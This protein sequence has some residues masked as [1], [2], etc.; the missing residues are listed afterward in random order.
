MNRP[1]VILALVLA[2]QLL[3]V[4]A[5]FWPGSNAA[6]DSAT[7]PLLDLQADTIDRLI[8]ADGTTSVMLARTGDSWHMPNYHGLPVDQQKLNRS[9]HDLPALARG[10]PVSNSPAAVNR[11]EVAEDNFQSHIE[12]FSNEESAGS[13]YLGT[14]PGFHKVHTRIA[15]DDAVYAVEFN[16]FDLPAQPD[17]WLDTG[18]LQMTD[19]QVV[20]GLDY[21]ILKTNAG[22]RDQSDN[23]PLQ[24][25]VDK[26]VNAL[27][28]LR[29]NAA[30]DLASAAV[31]KEMQAPPT[32]SVESS[33][34]SYA[35]RL[36]DIE[37]AYYIQRDD[38]P[39]YFSLSAMDYDRLSEVTA[40]TLKASL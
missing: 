1:N 21:R 31:F 7:H 30:A 29:I 17:Q 13:L 36:Y 6:E 40:E 28:S 14:A 12:Y 11:F 24:S 19:V 38:I 5:V 22:W 3:L 4:A 18:M 15:G 27:T 32:L 16:T 8:V 25:E 37:G 34:G 23:T 26:L 10:W 39:V 2:G 35:F 20:Q 9:L 33:Q